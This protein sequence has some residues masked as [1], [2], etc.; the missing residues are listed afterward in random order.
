[1]T[2]NG[3]WVALDQCKAKVNSARLHDVIE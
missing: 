3:V 1:L 2:D